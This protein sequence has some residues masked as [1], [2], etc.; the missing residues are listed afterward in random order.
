MSF[1]NPTALAYFTAVFK[2]KLP[3]ALSNLATL[4]CFKPLRFLGEL[5]CDSLSNKCGF[6]L[7]LWC[8]LLKLC[9]KLL[10]FHTFI[11]CF[12][13]INRYHF[14]TPLIVVLPYPKR[15]LE[16]FVIFS[17]KP[18]GLKSLYPFDAHKLYALCLLVL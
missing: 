15:F 7:K 5:F 17:Q 4:D 13:K 1:F 12:S 8:K 6:D 14:Q 16:S 2:I 9:L 3:F 10:I 18:Q 11:K